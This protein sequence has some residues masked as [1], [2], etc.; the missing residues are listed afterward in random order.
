MS[1]VKPGQVTA[2]I[3][4][5]FGSEGKGLIQGYIAAKGEFQYA[6]T[7][8]SANAGHTL[9]LGDGR[10]LVTYH[11]PLSGVVNGADMILSAGA[12]ID[13]IVLEDEIDA[14]E[15]LGVWQ[16]L[17]DRLFIHPRAAV[18]LPFDRDQEANP[19]SGAARIASTQH[20]V[21]SAIVRRIQR[22]ATLAG[23]DRRLARYIADIPLNAVLDDGA[24]VVLEI[25]QGLGL[26]LYSGLKYPYCTGR[27]V[28]VGQGMTDAQIDPRFLG[29]VMMVVRTYPIRVGN[30]PGV[31]ESGPFYPDGPEITWDVIGVAPEI[32]TVTKRVRRVATFSM[33]QYQQA[34][35][36]IRPTHV[37][38][39][40]MNYLPPEKQGEFLLRFAFIQAPTHL[41]FGPK[42]SDVQET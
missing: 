10:K 4:G 25:P 38:M 19:T 12:V 8:A 22:T 13:P 17:R 14:I 23:N 36:L 15:A 21:G 31:G 16:S 30:I 32:T 20:G 7:S 34:I 35:K 24:S 11:L 27:E 5:Q 41:G 6:V 18:I 1:L 3:G 39:N 37:F 40:F 33:E 9:I 2:I 42:V 29:S 26:G 28:S